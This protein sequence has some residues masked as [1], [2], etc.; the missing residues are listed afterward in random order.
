MFEKFLKAL[1]SPEFLLLL[2]VTVSVQSPVAL[3]SPKAKAI[4]MGIDG[5]SLDR[6]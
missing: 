1:R 4:R 5:A 6:P 3:R 2:L